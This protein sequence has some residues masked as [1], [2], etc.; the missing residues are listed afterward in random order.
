MYFVSLTNS[1]STAAPQKDI[2]SHF[3]RVSTKQMTFSTS[4]LLTFSREDLEKSFTRN[5]GKVLQMY[6]AE[7]QSGQSVERNSFPSL[8]TRLS[9]V[10]LNLISIDPL[11]LDSLVQLLKD[12]SADFVENCDYQV[13]SILFSSEEATNADKRQKLAA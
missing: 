12:L 3:A 11:F 6:F 2:F 1:L 13:I 8:A 4:D 10:F 7:K 5:I 9:K